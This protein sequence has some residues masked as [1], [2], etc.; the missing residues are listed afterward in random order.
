M[1]KV[2]FGYDITIYV[3]ISKEDFDL[4]CSAFE[5]HYEVKKHIELGG[6]MYGKKGR[7]DWEYKQGEKMILDLTDYQIDK[8]CKA[9]ELAS[10]GSEKRFELGKLYKELFNLHLEIVAEPKELNN[11]YNSSIRYFIKLQ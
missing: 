2:E 9:I 10:F 8:C 3:E 5:S 4:L 6:W 1:K 11:D 7:L